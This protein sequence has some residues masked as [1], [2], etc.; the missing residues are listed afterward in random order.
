MVALLER[1]NAQLERQHLAAEAV[2]GRAAAA[3]ATSGDFRGADGAAGVGDAA[4]GAGA[5]DAAPTGAPRAVGA[6]AA[7]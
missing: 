2:G 1:L 4:V 5:W 7:R 3:A 6:W